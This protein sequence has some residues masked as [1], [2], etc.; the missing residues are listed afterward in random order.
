LLFSAVTWKISKEL[1]RKFITSAVLRCIWQA[2]RKTDAGGAER[3][4]GAEKGEWL[5]SSA[6]RFLTPNFRFGLAP[7]RNKSSRSD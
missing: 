5:E 3:A 1:C 2:F 7:G 4:E 6:A